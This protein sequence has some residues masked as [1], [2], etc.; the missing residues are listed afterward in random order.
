MK[1]WILKS[2][3]DWT[4][5]YDSAFGFVVRAETETQAREVASHRAGDE[6]GVVWLDAAL[7]TCE[8]LPTDGEPCVVLRDFAA[9]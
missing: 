7:T 6:G 3:T 9:A 1:L 5:W 4:P 2:V 8:E